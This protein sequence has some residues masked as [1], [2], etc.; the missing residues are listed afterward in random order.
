MD[1]REY[2]IKELPKVENMEDKA[3]IAHNALREIQLLV[4]EDSKIGK[5]ITKAMDDWN[6][7]YDNEMQKRMNDHILKMVDLFSE[8]GHS[9]TSASYAISRIKRLLCRK[10][11]G[12]LTGEDDEWDEWSTDKYQ[13][14]RF[15]EVFKDGKAGKGYWMKGKVFSDDGKTWY[16]N[17]NSR[18][19]IDF[20]FDVPDEPEYID[21]SKTR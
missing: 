14:R 6:E 12:P 8:E 3:C 19:Y 2:A 5:T 11:L 4:T 18:V 7:S 10:P 17:K 1:L 16:T 15:S 13:N 9:G 21:L 20:P